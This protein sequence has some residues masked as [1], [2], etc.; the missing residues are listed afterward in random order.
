MLKNKRTIEQNNIPK[1]PGYLS[2]FMER[3]R[4]IKE[5]LEGIGSNK[6]YVDFIIANFYKQRFIS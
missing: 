6:K 4:K 3:R 2:T 5:L 1:F